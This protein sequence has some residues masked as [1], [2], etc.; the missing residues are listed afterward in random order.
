MAYV[1]DCTYCGQM[2]AN[3]AWHTEC[4]LEHLE[5]LVARIQEHLKHAS[6]PLPDDLQKEINAEQVTTKEEFKKRRK[7]KENR[8]Q[9]KELWKMARQNH[10]QRCADEFEKKHPDPDPILY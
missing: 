2:I 3:A 9:K 7:N 8:K 10:L 6:Q 1:N 5:D 4:R